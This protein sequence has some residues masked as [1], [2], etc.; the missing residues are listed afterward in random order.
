M[1]RLFPVYVSVSKLFIYYFILIF[2]AV[3]G[4]KKSDINSSDSSFVSKNNRTYC[5]KVL[6][7]LETQKVTVINAKASATNQN[8]NIDLLEENLDF[9]AARTERLDNNLDFLIV[10]IK[11]EVINRKNLDKNSIL[12]LLLI[13]DKSGK[14][15]SGSIVYF[16]P[17]EGKKHVSIPQNTFSNMFSG[18]GN[19]VALDGMYKI[20]T[21][22]GRCIS[23][24]GIKNGKLFSAGQVQQKNKAKENP[25]KPS[26][27]CTDWY[28]VTTY[29]WSDGSTTEMEV[30]QKKRDI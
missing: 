22:T 27:R 10:P 8:A 15:N 7:Y 13:T 21:P 28:L 2:F 24:F 23:Q 16:L 18:Y 12:T 26:A 6:A 4:C 20:L 9:V 19:R 29:Y 17:S 30:L 11:D 3:L 25:Q 14:I 5:D 1:R